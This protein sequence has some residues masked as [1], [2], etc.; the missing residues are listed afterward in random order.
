M[1]AGLTIASWRLRRE[2]TK[3][4]MGEALRAPDARAHDRAPA[5]LEIPTQQRWSP[6]SSV[7]R[8]VVS[9]VLSA[10]GSGSLLSVLAALRFA[11]HAMRRRFNP[12]ESTDVI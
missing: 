2:E 5:S 1:G 3:Q 8:S 7:M 11:R 9:I 10:V 6:M 4:P 12:K